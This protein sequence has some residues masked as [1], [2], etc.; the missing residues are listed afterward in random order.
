MAIFDDIQ[1]RVFSSYVKIPLIFFIPALTMLS[2]LCLVYF[3]INSPHVWR[4]VESSYQ[5]QLRGHVGVHYLDLGMSLTEVELYGGE[6]MT[7]DH[8]RVATVERVKLR[9]NPW[10]LM[11]GRV[12]FSRAELEGAAVRLEFRDGQMNLFEALGYYQDDPEEEEDEEG[13]SRRPPI[14]FSDIEIRD[15]HFELAHRY[16]EFEVPEVNI[17]QGSVFIE[18]ATVLM[19]VDELDLPG[20]QFR[21]FHH[22]FEFPPEY[23]TWEFDVGRFQLQNWQWANR[24]FSVDDVSTEVEGIRIDAQG[25]MAF[26]STAEGREMH[27]DAVGSIEADY[28]STALEYFTGGNIRFDVPEL[29]I[30]VTGDFNEIHAQIEAMAR[31]VQINGM[32]IENIRGDVEMRNRFLIGEGLTADFYEG[33]LETGYAF[34]SIYDRFFGAEVAAEGVNPRAMMGDLVL[35]DYPFLDGEVR[36][37]LDLIGEIPREARPRLTHNHVLATDALGRLMEVEVS[38]ELVFD[39]ANDQLF[40]NAQI[41]MQPGGQFFVDQ[42]RLGLH[43]ARIVDGPDRVDFREFYLS[44]PEMNFERVGGSGVARLSGVIGDIAPY[45]TYYNTDGLEGD[46]RF[47]MT[48]E[49][50][51]GSPRWRLNGEMDE[52]GWRVGE[53]EVLWGDELALELNTEDGVIGVEHLV[54]QAPFGRFS[55]EGWMAWYEPPPDEDHRG[56]AP[57]WEDREVQDIELDVDIDAFEME[58]ISHLLSPYLDARGQVDG[59]LWLRDSMQAMSGRFDA[60]VVDG[61]VRGQRIQRGE[62]EGGFEPSGVWLDRWQTD[63]AEAG[64]L[65]GAG[66]YDYGGEYV[67][68]AGGEDVRLGALEEVQQLGLGLD[69]LAQFQVAGEGESVRP[70][71]SGRGQIMDVMLAGRSYG[72]IVAVAET[73]EGVTYLSGGLLPWLTA[74]IELPLDERRPMYFRFGMED[75]A[76]MDFLPELQDHPMLDEARVTGIAEVYV[77]RDFSSYQVVFT[78]DDLEVDSRGQL[79][80]NRGQVVIGLTNAEVLSFDEARFESGGREFS[81]SGAV[82]LQPALLDLRVDGEFDLALLDSVRAGFPEFFPEYFVD[83]EGGATVAMNIRGT[84]DN[85][86]A[87][88]QVDYGPSQWDL[89]FLPEPVT[90]EGGRMYFGDRGIEIPEDRPMEGTML[91]G[92]G[93]VV[94]TIGYLPEHPREMDLEV[95]SHNMTY[96]FPDLATVVFDTNLRLEASD[97]HDFE[98]WLISGDV[99]LLDGLYEQEFNFVEQELAG[100]VIGAFQPQMEQYEADLFELIPSLNDIR[101]DTQVRAR[102]GFFLRTSL[103]RLEMDLEFRFDLLIQETLVDPTVVGDLDVISGDVSFQGEVF[104]VRSGTVRFSDDWTNPRLEIQATSDVRATCDE[105]AFQ[106]EMS[107]S[108]TLM[109]NME[110][111]ELEYYH[112]VMT[113]EGELE[114]LDLRLES[115]PYADQRDILSLLLTGCTVDELTASGASRPT[116]EVALGPLLGRLEREIQDVVAVDEFTITP[117]VERTQVQIGDTLTRRLSWRFFLDTGF[118]EATGGQQYQLEYRLSDHWTAEMSER[119]HL[120]SDN[121]L[122]DLKL[123]Y[124]LPL[125]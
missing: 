38:E 86:V 1:V 50:F 72:D 106:D 18:P 55:V 113:I 76:L 78:L 57:I 73:I 53:E 56:P 49:E 118:T 23:G 111:A 81:L 69:G 4:F 109:S 25:R 99:D 28:H 21:F 125:D 68:E 90:L 102:D 87:D 39:R 62:V 120:E 101:F 16:F 121:F 79:V 74:A 10:M 116:L 107:P 29:D 43:R 37:G 14:G 13:E 15:S 65:H 110:A 6:W 8:R 91:G 59:A 104:E 32:F 27:Y 11:V 83:A 64:L 48:M 61:S 84:P 60:E 35:E 26:P 117:G 41:R 123:N 103:D 33:Q 45:A 92:A 105:S 9:L 30:Q 122:L 17:P 63:L 93:R 36:G 46:G 40:P 95:W 31:V 75:L 67:F 112:I 52:V 66:R 34:F 98:T 42:R 97:W 24:G 2:A 19:S 100:R 94:G 108:M 89:R 82:S 114:N 44:Y 77:A 5:E 96:R 7:P 70:R 51:F 12:E 124:R 88:G 3:H 47:E 20:G 85:F 54:A 58:A 71:L 115:N 119:S 22:L 80:R